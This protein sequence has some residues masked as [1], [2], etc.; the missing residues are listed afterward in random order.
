[1]F[2]IDGIPQKSLLNAP[3]FDTTDILQNILSIS[4]EDIQSIEILKNVPSVLLYGVD[5]AN[6][7]IYIETKKGNAHKPVFTYELNQGFIPEPTFPKLLNGDQYSMYQLEAHHNT[8][9]MTDIPPELAYDREYAQY[10]NYSQNTDW[11][12][13]VTQPAS[14]SNHFLNVSGGTKNSRYYGSINYNNAKGSVIN[15]GYQ[16]LLNRLHYEHYFSKSFTLGA[17]F[18]YALF[19]LNDNLSIDSRDILEMA[20]IKAPNMSIWEYDQTGNKTGEYFRPIGTYQGQGSTYYNPV[21]VAE[22][23]YSLLPPPYSLFSPPC[24]IFPIH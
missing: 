20:Y 3:D 8:Y 11:V 10:Y 22:F 21:A 18:H 7:V 16:Q 24:F 4:P 13:A 23:S 17:N 1:M 14:S 2:V 12:K 19:D 6:G 9:G 15:T 5:G